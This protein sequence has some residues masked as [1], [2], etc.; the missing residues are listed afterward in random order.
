[1][2]FLNKVKYLVTACFLCSA[3]ATLN[4]EIALMPQA[5]EHPALS[6]PEMMHKDDRSRLAEFYRRYELYLKK[7][8]AWKKSFSK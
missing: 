4:P 1:M 8:S 2:L 6:Y 7:L 3:C 5:P